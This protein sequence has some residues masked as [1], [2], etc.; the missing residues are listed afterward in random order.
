MASNDFSGIKTPTKFYDLNFPIWKVKMILFLKSLSNKVAKSVIKKFV[1]PQGDE[2]TWS[3]TTAKKNEANA[4]SHYA[5][6]LHS[7]MM[8]YHVL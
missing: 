1:E 2:D 5:L 8:I 7:M 6:L 4:K 3:D